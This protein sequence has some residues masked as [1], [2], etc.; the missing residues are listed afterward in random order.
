MSRR[1][2]LRIEL[3]LAAALR[4]STH[5]YDAAMIVWQRMPWHHGIDN[6]RLWRNQRR[7]ADRSQDGSDD[8]WLGQRRGRGRLFWVRGDGHLCYHDH[9]HGENCTQCGGGY[10]V[11]MK[12]HWMILVS[13]LCSGFQSACALSERRINLKNRNRCGTPPLRGSLRSRA[14]GA[15]IEPA[16]AAV[17]GSTKLNSPKTKEGSPLAVVDFGVAP[18]FCC[19]RVDGAHDGAEMSDLP[20]GSGARQRRWWRRPRA[21]NGLKS[22]DPS[23]LDQY[24][25]L[26]FYPGLTV[27]ISR[28]VRRSQFL[29]HLASN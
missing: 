29:K 13:G 3:D 6:R 14:G 25:A 2:G 21:L 24:D 15:R 19:G 17:A 5:E 26:C 1:N 27:G 11:A 8:G 23:R 16:D 22:T 10:R 18:S 9:G 12:S 4:L 20:R 7:A 28:S